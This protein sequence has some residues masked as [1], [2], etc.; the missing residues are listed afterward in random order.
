MPG[1]PPKHPANRRR[2]NQSP[3][4]RILPASGRPGRAPKWPLEVKPS[5]VQAARWRALWCTPQALAWDDMGDVSSAV[6]Y[7]VLLE[8][9]V[10]DPDATTTHRNEFR[11]MSD[12]LGLNPRALRSLGWHVDDVE[13]E[14]APLATV[15]SLTS[16]RDRLAAGS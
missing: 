12:R 6:A 13:I 7:F 2:R 15:P 14:Q 1:P 9:W 10:M 3:T 16:Y 8:S 11:Q 5:K 4:F